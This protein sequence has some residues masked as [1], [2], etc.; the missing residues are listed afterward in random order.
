MSDTAPH[1]RWPQVLLRTLFLFVAISFAAVLLG[2]ISY[3]AAG[4][5][6]GLLIVGALAI[7]QLPL[8]LLF[9]WMFNR[10]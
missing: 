5:L 3:G 1:R 4:A 10:R 7:L 2:F 6:G 9:S 8:Y